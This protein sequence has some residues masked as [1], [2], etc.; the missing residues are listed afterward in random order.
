MTDALLRVKMSADEL[1]GLTKVVSI[2]I[3]AV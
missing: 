3:I 1:F 2:A